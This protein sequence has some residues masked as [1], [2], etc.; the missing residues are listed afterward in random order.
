MNKLP[1]FYVDTNDERIVRFV[2]KNRT[3]RMKRYA[4]PMFAHFFLGA[5]PCSIE[6]AIRIMES[7]DI[8]FLE[9]DSDEKDIC[10]GL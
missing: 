4:L 9:E 10:I 6:Q 2:Y 7:E 1:T 3:H 8:K 5:L